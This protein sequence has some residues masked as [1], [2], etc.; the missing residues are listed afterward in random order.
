MVYVTQAYPGL[1]P[2]LKD[3]HFLLEMWRDGQDS[4][5]WKIRG[6]STRVNNG[7]EA[8]LMEINDIENI[9]I[10]LMTH[11]DCE[12][13]S[14]RDGPSSGLTP[15]APQFK[16]D[17]KA[18][19]HLTKAEQPQVQSARN[20]LT[21]TAYYSFRDALSGGFGA[22]IERPGGLHGH[23]GLWGKDDKEQS[24]NYQELCNL[25]DTVEDEAKEGHLR[26]GELWLFT[27]NSTAKNCF[28][29]G[30]SSSKLLHEL[31]LRLRKA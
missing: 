31:V 15:V 30:R 28:F 9:K 22:T 3:F 6:N 1:K 4:E 26:D 23:F 29:Q 25:V 11:N 12:R 18:I 2:Y 16:Q 20:K 13:E 21:I 24:S 27:D 19:L 10:Q 14:L 7:A 17:L 5:G 8:S